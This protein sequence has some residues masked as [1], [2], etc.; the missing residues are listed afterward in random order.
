[1][2]KMLL[3]IVT[4]ERLISSEE[5]DVLVAPG[6]EG[7]LSILPNHAPLLTSLASGE[8]RII[9]DG[10]ERYISVSGGFLE[11]I[12]NKVTI[13]ADAAERADEIDIKRSEDALRR[14]KDR[15]QNAVDDVDLER[16]LASVRRSQARLTVARRRQRK[17]SASTPL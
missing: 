6:S 2:G 10:N 1:M 13:L 3:D 12:D 11:I 16:A 14:A 5:V 7:E 15:V 9:T 4:A 17:S 8:V